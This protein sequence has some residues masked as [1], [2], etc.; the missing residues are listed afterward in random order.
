MVLEVFIWWHSLRSLYILFKKKFFFFFYM[1]IVLLDEIKIILARGSLFFTIQH[2][3]SLYGR[4]YIIAHYSPSVRII[5]LFSHITYV[6]C[7]GYVSE[8]TYSLKATPNDRFF[9]KLFLA[10]IFT[11]RIFGRNLLKGSCRRNT[12]RVLFWCLALVLNHGFTSNKPTLPSRLRRL[13]D[14]T[15]TK[16]VR[17]IVTNGII[18][19]VDRLSWKT[20]W[21]VLLLQR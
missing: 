21:H 12:F 16:I 11:L 14:R 19:W 4:T 18:V 10:I 1:E 6:V 15:Y 2:N 13:Y 5:N 17:P 20:A 3:P 9:D 7:V 8:R